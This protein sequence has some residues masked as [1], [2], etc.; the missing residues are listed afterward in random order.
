MK[1]II[2]L[3]LV[4][5]IWQPGRAETQWISD[6]QPNPLVYTGFGDGIANMDDWLVV[7][8]P[9]N[10]DL[11][12]DAGAI[13]VYQDNGGQW[14]LFQTLY[15]VAADINDSLVNDQFG[16][17][18]D[19]ER[20]HQTGEVWIVGSAIKD[21]DID[22]DNGAVYAFNLEDQ[23]GGQFSFVFRKKFIGET[24][25]TQNFGISI[26][27]NYDYIEEIDAHLWVLAI[28]D[29]YY[30]NTVLG[31]TRATGGIT[32]YKKTDGIA[33]TFWEQEPVQI[34][35]I[36]IDGLSST[37]FIGRSVAIDG[38]TIVAG[39]PGDD[40]H[41]LPGQDGVDMGAVHV[42]QRDNLT[43]TWACCSIIYPDNRERG[44]QFG[45][46]VDVIKQ[47][48]NNRII[49][50]GAPYERDGNNQPQGSVYVWFNGLM[51]QRLQPQLFPGTTGAFFGGSLAANGDAFFGTNQLIIGA[52][53]SEDKRGRI[54]HY[55]LNPGFD[56]FNDLYL[57]YDT[58]V[59]YNRNVVP[60]DV[61]QFGF[62]VTTDGRNHATS[63]VANRIGNHKSVYTK[64]YPI[65]ANG[66]GSNVQQ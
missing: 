18:V 22:L 65:F 44:A 28:G 2:L 49:M 25:V 43:Q 33:N 50:G 34:G 41:A 23:G 3:S 13:Y 53:Y 4:L 54:H 30:R 26:A 42:Y 58:I 51:V 1:N 16:F 63:S 39:A 48:N 12:T 20:N 40:D 11:A 47:P 57:V 38:K 6:I 5:S 60:W 14:S 17:A 46:A 29:D 59:A 9:L 56:G 7:G 15:P 61:G 55:L 32:I 19:I 66:F 31:Q 8:D 37:D 45:Y 24:L 36:Y 27:L 62:N 21:D 35:Q 10:D 64:E 52:P